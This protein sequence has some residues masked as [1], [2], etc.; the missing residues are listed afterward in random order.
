MAK[1]IYRRHRLF[2]ITRERKRSGNKPFRYGFNAQF[3][4]YIS[5]EGKFA[6][7]DQVWLGTNQTGTIEFEQACDRGGYDLQR[8]VRPGFKFRNRVEAEQFYTLMVLS[9]GD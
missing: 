4:W 3:G 9:I 8:M 2:H 1:T 5:T 6:A 7:H